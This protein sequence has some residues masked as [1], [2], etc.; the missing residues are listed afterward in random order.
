MARGARYSRFIM[1][2]FSRFHI[3]S[4]FSSDAD[5]YVISRLRSVFILQYLCAPRKRAALA[6]S[7]RARVRVACVI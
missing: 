1:P 2:R 3:S 4:S 7:M 6:Q 5:D